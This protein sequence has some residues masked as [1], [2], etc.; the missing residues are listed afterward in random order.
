MKKILV[1]ALAMAAMATAVNA[2]DVAAPA[3]EDLLLAGIVQGEVGYRWASG[4]DV[5]DEEMIAIF[6]SGRLS[7]PLGSAFSIQGDL[8]GENYFTSEDDDDP[9]LA[10]A[11]GLHLSLRNPEIGLVG[12]FGAAGEGD[13]SDSNNPDTGI[14][15]GIE[16]Q[17]Y[18]SDLTLYA[19]AGLADVEIDSQE[20]FLDGWFVRGVA[21][22]FIDP[23][24]QLSG[25]V[26]YG[27]ADEFT[28]DGNPGQG[29]NWEISARHRLMELPIYGLIAYRGGHYSDDDG[30]KEA[31]DHAV[32][33][34]FEMAFGADTL[35]D[36]DRRGATLDIP[37]LPFRAS[38]Y[39]E[40]LD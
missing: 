29:V 5:D 8:N 24:F 32:S 3:P 22:Y 23:D 40:T 39:G 31:E 30:G 20:G 13:V 28:D 37:M 10:Y 25:E 12:L 6:G 33:V 18:L 19:Q 9:E 16:A 4:E 7:V 21:R 11:A 26:A 35:Q 27:E 36:N 38:A 15:G 1:S 14:L 17:F 2:A 34:G